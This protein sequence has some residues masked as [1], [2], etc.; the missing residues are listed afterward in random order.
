[1]MP[2][3][4]GSGAGDRVMYMQVAGSQNKDKNLIIIIVLLATLISTQLN[5]ILGRVTKL[6]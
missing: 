5:R 2:T 3:V 4:W 1:M 6:S